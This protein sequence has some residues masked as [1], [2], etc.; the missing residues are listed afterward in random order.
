MTP[1]LA[2]QWALIKP[3]W[4]ILLV[5]VLVQLA[6]SAFAAFYHL[7]GELFFDLWY[8]GVV[9]TPIG[10]VLGLGWHLTSVKNGFAK[11]KQ[12]ILFL[13]LL[14]LLLPMFAMIASNL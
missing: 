2:E 14:S 11:Y 13:G 6:G 7:T 8:G 3:V 5:V 4:R 12:I 1:S 9:V 10:F